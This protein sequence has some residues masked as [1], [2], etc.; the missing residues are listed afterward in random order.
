MNESKTLRAHPSIQTYIAGPKLNPE[1]L[2]NRQ[3]Q[4]TPLGV[5]R[6]QAKEASL[7]SIM[8]PEVV[9]G[10]NFR[11]FQHT[12]TL[13]MDQTALFTRSQTAFHALE[14]YNDPHISKPSSHRTPYIESDYTRERVSHK[15][16]YL[17][18]YDFC[19]EL[20]GSTRPPYNLT[21][22]RN[23]FIQEGGQTG[24]RLFPNQDTME[25]WNSHKSWLQVKSAIK[26]LS[27]DTD[28]ANKAVQ[29]RAIL[30]F[31]GILVDPK[32]ETFQGDPGLEVFWFTHSNDL[33]AS[34]TFLGRRIRT[35][36]PFINKQLLND[37]G[38]QV[39][40]DEISILYFTNLV[41]DDDE[42][43]V[44]IR[45]TA[46]DGFST[47]FNSYMTGFT[48][49]KRVNNARQL[50]SLTY[51]APTT[52]TMKE[53]WI[54]QKDRANLLSGYYHQGIGG[55]YYKLELW[56]GY[57]WNQIPRTMLSLTRDPFAPMFSFEV[58][59][60]SSKYGCDFPFCDR[61]FGGHKMKWAN[62]MGGGPNW[63]YSIVPNQEFPFGKSAMIFSPG[64]GGIHSRFSLKLYSFMTMTLLVRIKIIPARSTD[65][66]RFHSPLGTIGICIRSVSGSAEVYLSTSNNGESTEN[67]VIPLGEP[68][69]IVFRALRNE[70]DI[71]T[72]NSIQI[73]AKSLRALQI[74]P[75]EF[76]ESKPLVYKDPTKL[77][78]SMT[79]NAYTLH[80]GGQSNITAYWL[81][82][83]D[84][85]LKS[86][87][88]KKESL[89]TWSCM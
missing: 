1:A 66:L 38:S 58:E 52:F 77:E 19:S 31:L 35:T 68:C 20:H 33:T 26:Q 39:K 72:L 50:T 5:N 13:G 2:I 49:A 30:N 11:D 43:S 46:D 56:D 76:K 6:G 47:H 70:Y 74:R 4:V 29:Q 15:K 28:S 14:A 65:I 54:L 61:R 41:I 24:A 59:K 62:D 88:L 32:K 63:D 27:S 87:H 23:L 69:L 16:E 21:C 60:G 67:P 22:L 37:D 51:M 86:D 18:S 80:M 55:F 85:E 82:F 84:Y 45:V 7:M 78:N 8:Y 36:I 71:N 3:L 12:A 79:K 53:E 40:K 83:F 17:E 44:F 10:S 73:G 25:F 75:E 48:N 34:T 64:G 9:R 89:Q 57:T 81:H 42:K